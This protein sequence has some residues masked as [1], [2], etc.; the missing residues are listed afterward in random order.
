MFYSRYSS[1]TLVSRAITRYE[2][3]IRT[4]SFLFLQTKGSSSDDT[5]IIRSTHR[6]SIAH[7]AIEEY[8]V[9][10]ENTAQQT[11]DLALLHA[12]KFISRNWSKIGEKKVF[13]QKA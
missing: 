6:L 12:G 9:E 11:A 5:E 3:R 2:K 1:W 7:V 10:K 4:K 8:I 13:M